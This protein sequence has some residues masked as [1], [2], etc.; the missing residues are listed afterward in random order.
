METYILK[1]IFCSSA[2]IVLY[3]IFLEREKIHQFN[4]FF[5]I[6]S[7]LFSL[8]IPLIS[9]T[10]GTIPAV[11]HSISMEESSGVF[12]QIQQKN[13]VFTTQNIT[14][15]I[16]LM[17][18]L[19]LF[20]RFSFSILSLK[21]EIGKGKKIKEG[22][23]TFILKEEKTT[24]H[25][26]LN[27]IFLNKNDFENGKIDRKIIEHEKTHAV[28]KH[29]IDNLFIEFLLVAFWFNPAF[30]FYKK[31]ILTNHEFLADENVL[32]QNPNFADYKKLLLIELISENIL[33]TNKF[34]F[35]NTKKRLV[36][37]TKKPTFTAKLKKYLVLPV[38]AVLFFV[39]VEKVPAQKNV[40]ATKKNQEI[41]MDK[42]VP[43]S[44]ENATPEERKMIE[45]FEN[46]VKSGNVK[47][48][49]LDT[50]RKRKNVENVK[51]EKAS[52]ITQTKSLDNERPDTLPMFPN[53]LNSFRMLVNTNFDA[54]VFEGNEGL[55]KTE[56]FVTIDDFG[57]VTNVAAEGTN[58]KFNA[59]AKRSVQEAS[60]GITWIP[61]TKDGKHVASVFKLPLTMM[62]EK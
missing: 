50:I 35:N 58:E 5:L 44:K 27:Y 48:I 13:A 45:K 51:E 56:V 54:T 4:R 37:M 18:A 36:M 6:S 52:P 62:F 3:Y 40:E 46:E 53:G 61:A 28:Q 38:S 8:L 12:S 7:V 41:K 55:I 19:I 11:E 33:F 9:I 31:A 14:F 59:E 34:N 16:Y 30:Y 10:Y 49:K 21:K 2:F 42:A 32:Q 20:T 22:K 15:G 29:G 60:K 17:V 23:V 57:K 25:S 1:M 43:I 39:F 47:T 26:F 24:P